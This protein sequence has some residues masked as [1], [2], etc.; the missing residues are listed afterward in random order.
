MELLYA[1]YGLLFVCVWLVTFSV[2]KGL[3]QAE[4]HLPADYKDHAVYPGMEG[5]DAALKRFLNKP[6][7]LI[8]SLSQ[9]S[10]FLPL[11]YIDNFKKKLV[12]AGKPLN[13]SQFLAFKV[14]VL[15]AFPFLLYLFLPQ[16]MQPLML[17]AA[18]VIG[19]LMPD[20]WLK[21]KIAVR[22]KQVIRDMPYIIELMNICVSSGLDFMVAVNRVTQ[23]F[24]D[25]PMTEE[26]GIMMREIQMGSSRRDS[27]KNLAQRV[28]SPEVS[29]FVLTLLQ[30]DR[31][32]TPIGKILKSQADEMRVR[33]FQK[34]EEQALKAPI[35]LLFPLL[36]F[37]MPVVLIIVAGPILIQF[38]YGGLKLY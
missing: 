34:G 33:R 30:A 24:R 13:I 4:V 19:F 10:N 9:R 21:S 26:L 18:G 7:N 5:S 36:F 6:A 15:V 38:I 1:V 31:M 8:D 35:K 14:I 25:C 20:F 23:E 3:S 2:L 37:V 22:Q 17:L 32:G 11:V 29:S 28:N 27:L 16:L 12:S